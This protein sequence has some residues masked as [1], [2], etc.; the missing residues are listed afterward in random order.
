MGEWAQLRSATVARPGLERGLWYRVQSRGR[1][2]SI[3]I[4]GPEGGVIDCQ[5]HTI[6]VIDHD[7]D[8]ITRV[9]QAA[10]LPVR[11]GEPAPTVTHYGHCPRGHWI[12][13]VPAGAAELRC[14]DCD[15]LYKVEDETV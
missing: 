7:P 9:E 6:H 13:N 1:D 5:P 2:G 10:F 14:A 3:R 8:T 15:L 12:R 11:P 4:I